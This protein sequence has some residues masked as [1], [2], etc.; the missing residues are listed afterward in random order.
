ME[1]YSK[2]IDMVLMEHLC[3][4]EIQAYDPLK[5]TEYNQIV[6]IKKQMGNRDGS[7]FE[8]DLF[9]GKGV[10]DIRFKSG[11]YNDIETVI[12]ELGRIMQMIV[13]SNKKKESFMENDIRKGK[14]IEFQGSWMSGLAQLVIEDSETGAIESICCENASTVRAL[15]DA[16]G[17]V[18][19]GNHS[20]NNSAITGKEILLSSDGLI[21]SGFTPMEE[22][23]EELLE[24]Y[25]KSKLER[26][27]VNEH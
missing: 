1:K 18:I 4:I 5:P 8:I 22:A 6:T 14:I 9:N 25:E 26:G 13:D 15:D 24:L 23:G 16:Y 19:D 11:D 20:L 10:M 2:L 7:S 17:D 12:L 21:M 27:K 3:S